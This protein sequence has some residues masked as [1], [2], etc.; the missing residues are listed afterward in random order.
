MYGSVSI[1]NPQFSGPGGT[2]DCAGHSIIGNGTGYGV[3]LYSAYNVTIKNCVI[4][5][6]SKGIYVWSRGSG[7]KLIGNTVSDN[8]YG[9]IVLDY[10]TQGN[11]IRDNTLSN[12]RYYGIALF[13]QVQHH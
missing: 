2:L 3:F 10:R 8:N 6:F 12:N 9:G 11:T 4:K 13:F 1:G 5:N 7:H